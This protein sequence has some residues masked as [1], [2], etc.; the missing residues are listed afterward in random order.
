M[1]ATDAL[2][3]VNHITK[4]MRLQSYTG[5]YTGCYTVESTQKMFSQL[6]HSA[7]LILDTSQVHTYFAKQ[8]AML[9]WRL[10]V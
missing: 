4:D 1:G 3:F 5:C 8:K 9:V 10:V 6:Q 2:D 7:I